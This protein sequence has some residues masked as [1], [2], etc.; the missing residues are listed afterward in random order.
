ML[1][2]GYADILCPGLELATGSDAPK[3]PG[4]LVQ[5]GGNRGA[6]YEIVAVVDETAWVREPAT[7]RNESLVPVSRL[8][9]AYPALG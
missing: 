6:I 7:H 3:T 9:L 1:A 4:T 2:T 8:R 5:L